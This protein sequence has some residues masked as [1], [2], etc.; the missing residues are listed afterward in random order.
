MFEAFRL[1]VYCRLG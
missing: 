1:A